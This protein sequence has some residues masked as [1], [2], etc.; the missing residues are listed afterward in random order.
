MSEHRT[1]RRTPIHA[2]ASALV[3]AAML[4]G[5]GNDDS[6]KKSGNSQATDLKDVAAGTIVFRRFLNAEQTQAALFTMATDGK[7]ER[8]L[9]KP[10]AQ[11]IDSY[12]DWSP[13][14]EKIAFHREFSD[15][16]WEVYVVNSDGSG[17]KKVEP[18]RPPKLAANGI[19]DAAEPQWSPDGKNVGFSWAF[20]ELSTVRGEEQIE[21]AGIGTMPVDGSG[22]TL[23]TQTKR[24]GRTQDNTAVW[25][26]DGNRIAFVRTNIT[27]K[28]FDATAIFV[29][30]ADGTDERR[31]TPWRLN[32]KDPDWSPDGDV[33]SFR[34]ALSDDEFVGDIHTVRTDGSELTQLTRAKGK[35][36]YASSF[37]PDSQWI[38]F[39]MTGDADLPDLYLMR[40]DGTDLTPLTRTPEWESA[41]DW[42]PR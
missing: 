34:S 38:V 27:D 37:S 2:V 6:T 25:S 41:P 24:P 11:T 32:A 21:V 12:P 30:T 9:T 19:N 15:K 10:P 23:I 28:P 36:V 40:R 20:G 18:G 8:Q 31:I 35:E 4:A 13:D 29:A 14:G 42:S 7:G 22:A 26:P 17:Q 33:I 39:G 1:T 3:V 16:P 5:C